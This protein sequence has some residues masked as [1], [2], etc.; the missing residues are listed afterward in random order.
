MEAAL[1]VGLERLSTEISV[2]FDPVWATKKHTVAFTYGHFLD[3][4]KEQS[5]MPGRDIQLRSIEEGIWIK[6]KAW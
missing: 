5:Q 4:N 6:S 3:V 2:L 1:R